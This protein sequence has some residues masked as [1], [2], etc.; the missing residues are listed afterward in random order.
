MYHIIQDGATVATVDRLHFWKRQ[1]NGVNML[2][3]EPEANG[4]VVNDAFYHL[5]WMPQSGGGEPDVTYEEF[6]GTDTIAEL[7]ETVIDLEYQN[8]VLE[9]GVNED[10]V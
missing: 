1:K 8:I 6:S 4:I 10:A 3:P 5:P 9:M 7:D 2:C